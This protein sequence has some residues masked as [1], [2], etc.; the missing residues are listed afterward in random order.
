MQIKA[1]TMIELT[2]K[3]FAQEGW[4]KKAGESWIAKCKTM[5]DIEMDTKKNVFIATRKEPLR[6]VVLEEMLGKL[7]R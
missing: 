5:Y 4:T 3:I 7:F 2:R 1:K 6:L